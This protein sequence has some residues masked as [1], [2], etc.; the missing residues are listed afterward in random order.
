MKIMYKSLKYILFAA[1]I[2]LLAGSCN[3]YLDVKPETSVSED[4]AF[5]SV[6]GF[7]NALNGAY[8]KMTSYDMYGGKMNMLVPEVMGQRYAQGSLDNNYALATFSYGEA[9]VK[10]LMADFW[11][12]GYSLIANIN[13]ILDHLPAKKELFKETDYNLMYGEALALRTFMHF[14]LLRMFGP[15]YKVD[16]IGTYIPYYSWRASSARPYLEANKMM[17]SL[18]RDISDALKYLSNDLITGGPAEDASIF[19]LRKTRFNYYAAKALQARMFLY[20]LDMPNAFAAANEVISVQ[21]TLFAWTGNEIAQIAK[22]PALLGDCLFML[23]NIKLPTSYNNL[24]VYTLPAR[25]LLAPLGDVLK[26]IYPDAGDARNQSP[27]W[28]PAPDASKSN[29]FYKF[30][31]IYQEINN[32]TYQLNTM[33]PVI[34]AAECYLIAA[35]ADPDPADAVKYLDAIKLARKTNLTAPGAKVTSEI[36]LEYRREFYGEGQIFYF[37]KRTNAATI[38][39][40]TSTSATATQKMTAAK[41]IVPIP[42]DERLVH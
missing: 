31:P 8:L 16:S 15:V 41:Y 39:N 29:C 33:V 23:E 38:P 35:E 5:K 28:R 10:T 14:D 26:T 18:Q 2:L 3:K 12:N 21:P 42:D 4:D 32:V 6:S 1:G 36:A 25:S 22:D 13:N 7:N 27:V 11:T 20:R 9:K 17:D 24:F 37:Y 30:A 40:C 19:N 34:R